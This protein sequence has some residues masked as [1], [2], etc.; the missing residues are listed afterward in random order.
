MFLRVDDGGYEWRGLVFPNW[1]VFYVIV[2]T[3]EGAEG[4]A[5]HSR[6]GLV[7]CVY[8]RCVCLSVGFEHL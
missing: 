1:R 5:R 6:L 3:S 8:V 7:L 4:I 2:S